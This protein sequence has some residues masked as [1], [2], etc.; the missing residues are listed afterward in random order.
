MKTMQVEFPEH[1]EV[2]LRTATLQAKL[3][4]QIKA[5]M[6]RIRLAELMEDI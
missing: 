1:E 5:E 6:Q 4:S 2:Q 3:K